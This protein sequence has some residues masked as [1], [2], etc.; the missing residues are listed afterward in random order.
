MLR[1][2]ASEAAK[3]THAGRRALQGEGRRQVAPPAAKARAPALLGRFA[4]LPHSPRRACRGGGA[5]VRA[6]Q[7][8]LAVLVGGTPLQEL[9]TSS[10]ETYV[11]T[12]FNTP[13]SYK[14]AVTEVR[15][16]ARGARDR[17]DA[18]RRWIR[19]RRATPMAKCSRKTGRSRPTRCA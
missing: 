4:R 18:H 19:A 13:S 8:E 11:E 6:G 15:R 1:C 5:M 16:G 2:R 17:A 3:G 7:F 9:V 10:G 14:V 12:K